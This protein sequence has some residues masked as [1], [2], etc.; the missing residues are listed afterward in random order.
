MYRI[1]PLHIRPPLKREKQKKKSPK[2]LAFKQTIYSPP[3]RDSNLISIP[4]ERGNSYLEVAFINQGSQNLYHSTKPETRNIGS[5]VL[6][7]LPLYPQSSTI[8]YAIYLT[9]E[10][11]TYRHIEHIIHPIL[12]YLLYEFLAISVDGY[13]GL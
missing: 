5:L 8:T 13:N 12:R 3:Y 11:S 4:I 9:K 7:R 1:M 2:N 6:P 10:L